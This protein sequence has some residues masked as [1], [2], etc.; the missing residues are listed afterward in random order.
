MTSSTQM[1]YRGSGHKTIIPYVLFVIDGLIKTEA[2]K[3]TR[4]DI[5]RDT[6]DQIALSFLLVLVSVLD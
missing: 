3:I 5:A 2:K 6:D 1:I 4:S